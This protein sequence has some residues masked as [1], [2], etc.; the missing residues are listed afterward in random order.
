MTSGSNLGYDKITAGASES[1]VGA[2]IC[3]LFS[4]VSWAGGGA[5]CCFAA[6][7]L[8]HGPGT[9]GSC[10]LWLLQ[11]SRNVSVR[12]PYKVKLRT[13]SQYFVQDSECPQ[14][15]T[16]TH[17]AKQRRTDSALVLK[18]PHRT[19]CSGRFSPGM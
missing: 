13:D 1:G 16:R 15:E 2:A 7:S 18:T 8:A 17:S 11:D 10:R 12:A 19:D 3:E 4:R 5:G 9:E 6:A 14:E